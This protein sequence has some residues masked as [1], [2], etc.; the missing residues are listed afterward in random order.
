L[1]IPR[2]RHDLAVGEPDELAL[3]RQ[4]RV[5]VHDLMSERFVAS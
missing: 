4:R 2:P 3:E 1:R 5:P